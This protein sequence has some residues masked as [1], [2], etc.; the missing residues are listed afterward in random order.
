MNKLRIERHICTSTTTIEKFDKFQC[1]YE[2]L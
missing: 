1:L 2:Q